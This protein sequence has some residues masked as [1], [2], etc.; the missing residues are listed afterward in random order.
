MRDQRRWRRRI[1]IALVAAAALLPGGWAITRMWPI[2]Q[3]ATVSTFQVDTLAGQSKEIRLGT[4]QPF[5]L[6]F[7][8]TWCYPCREEWPDLN[9]AQRELRADGL[10]IVAISVN[11]PGTTVEAFLRTRPADVEVVLDP[12]G[13]TAARFGV[14]GF[15]THVL[16]DASGAVRAIV[17]GPLSGSRA[18]TLL[19][20]T[21][22]AAAPAVKQN[23]Y[24][25]A[26]CL[27][28]APC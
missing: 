1:Q 27:R 7:W 19:G 9:Q 16:I 17:R 2:R 20:L 4:G 14:T 15:P 11:E 24:P 5:W 3:A 28:P 8:A 23:R 26:R 10:R 21:A 22:H 13:A 6:S 12:R 25:S 18:R